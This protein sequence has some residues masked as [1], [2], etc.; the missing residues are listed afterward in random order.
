MRPDCSHMLLMS[1]TA[2]RSSRR[3]AHTCQTPGASVMSILP[4]SPT[5]SPVPR[6]LILSAMALPQHGCGLGGWIYPCLSVAVVPNDLM[7]VTARRGHSKLR[8]ALPLRIPAGDLQRGRTGRL[9]DK[10]G[11]ANR[12]R[13][14]HPYSHAAARL[15]QQTAVSAPAA[16]HGPNSPRRLIAKSM[17]GRANRGIQRRPVCGSAGAHPGGLAPIPR[18][19]GSA[20]AETVDAWQIIVRVINPKPTDQQLH[21]FSALL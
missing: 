1:H 3:Y 16:A 14:A 15:Q 10:N 18:C 17:G 8:A 7:D 19:F 20:G 11:S 12:A 21:H 2:Q 5:I 9:R 6:L 13:R 4:L